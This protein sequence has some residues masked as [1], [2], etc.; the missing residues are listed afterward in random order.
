[1][2]ASRLWSC[3]IRDEHTGGLVYEGLCRPIRLLTDE[4]YTR[5]MTTSVYEYGR[6]QSTNRPRFRLPYSSWF[7]ASARALTYGF[8]PPAAV[9]R[10]SPLASIQEV[11]SC[12]V[13]VCFPELSNENK[14]LLTWYNNAQNFPELSNENRAFIQQRT[15]SL[16]S[17]LLSRAI[18]KD[19]IPE[20]NS[21]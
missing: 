10:R 13:C 5:S 11:G 4:H 2:E 20:L 8:D 3:I 6:P 15:K 21:I 16:P 12:I 14:T 9:C 17:Q 7:S 18:R 19:F 1:M